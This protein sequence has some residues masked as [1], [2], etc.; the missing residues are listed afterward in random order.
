MK[1]QK[2]L[3]K[4]KLAV[5]GLF[6]LGV[7]W[8]SFQMIDSIYFGNAI[9]AIANHNYHDFIVD[10]LIAFT[11]IS[12]FAICIPINDHFR[13]Q[14]KQKM[15]GELRVE[16]ADAI[17]HL[18]Y[19]D[20]KE[21][22][23]AKYVSWMTNDLTIIDEQGFENIF[24]AIQT[25]T[26]V[27]I[28]AI[29][30]VKYHYSLLIMTIILAGLMIAGPKILQRKLERHSKTYSQA[31]E[32][33]TETMTDTFD[34]YNAL[35][36]LGQKNLITQRV[37]Q[38]SKKFGKAKVSFVTTKAENNGLINWISFLSQAAVVVLAGWL[39]LKG[40][41]KVGNIIT[42][43]SLAGVIFGNLTALSFSIVGLRTVKPI[44][45]KFQLQAVKE[46]KN[47]DNRHL[48]DFHQAI[49]LKNVT[50]KYSD[51][52]TPI[53]KNLSLQFQKNK[54]YALIA[55]SGFGKTTILNLI[56]DMYTDYS[57]DL[58]IDGYNY[59]D[60]P[61]NLIQAQ[62]LYVD[63]HPYIFSGS[64]KDNILMGRSIDNQELKQV[65]WTC[66]LDQFI[67]ALPNGIDTQ[68]R[69]SGANLSGGQTQRIAL[70]RM[71][72]SERP[73]LL[74]DEITSA[75]DLETALRVEENILKQPDKTVIM[76]THNLHDEMR[77]LL[78]NI[79][80]LTNY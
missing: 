78:D 61:E 22:D 16:I 14:L 76:V 55:P 54:K 53:I 63:Q 37:R 49:A 48:T 46:N 79:V 66:G 71:L 8:M 42:C 21:N 18:K 25:L 4:H 57:G 9:T 77:D 35:Y 32:Q 68:L 31:N 59:H 1:I 51:Q 30:I 39:A 15:E 56:F 19:A 3:F 73:I 47:E 23:T 7:F 45:E 58:T 74:L 80:D 70:A 34:G 38:A 41:M 13:E 33:L 26:A 11:A 2:Y 20:V 29:M 27:V 6:I 65:C 36:I 12:L 24:D 17:N 67:E 43:S 44:A 69:H 50:F 60:L 5:L 75:L 10:M 40:I 52:S 72:L 62:M 64:L 28:N